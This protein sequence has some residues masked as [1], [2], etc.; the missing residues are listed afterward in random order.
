MSAIHFEK[1]QAKTWSNYLLGKL[2]Q[3]SFMTT[4][5]LFHIL[6]IAMLGG[7]V[8]FKASTPERAFEVGSQGFLQD[9][10]DQE[11]ISQND[12]PAAEFEEPASPEIAPVAPVS[13]SAISALTESQTS[14][15]T[16]ASMDRASLGVSL[17]GTMSYPSGGA[18]SGARGSLTSGARSSFSFMGIRSESK[19][20]VFLLDASGSMIL[21]TKGGGKA[22][23]ELKDELVQLVDNLDSGTEFNVIMFGNGVDVFKPEIVRATDANVAELKQ[24]LAPYLRDK[25]GILRQTYQKS[26]FGEAWGSTR[27]DIAFNAAFEMQAETLFILT[28]GTPLVNRSVEAD[29]LKKW[30]ANREKNKKLYAEYE[31]SLEQYKVKFKDEYDAAVSKARSL[32]NAVE[33]RTQEVYGWIKFAPNFPKPPQGYNKP[34]DRVD[35]DEFNE[36]LK[37]MA[38]ELYAQK[39]SALPS[40]N[41]IGYYVNEEAEDYLAKM[42]KGF[43]GKYRSFKK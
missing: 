1:R 27:L 31:Q 10:A 4:S 33:G 35:A 32:N 39:N 30:E 21:E 17:S 34:R 9:S 11:P 5:L 16:S 26:P 13:Q 36:V 6:L 29:E 15:N 3:S 24:W 19:R 40:I 20:V 41:V 12:E 37:R 2:A 42:T 7:I 14:W 23:G 18:P 22:F 8:L 38:K 43:P 28:D 25:A